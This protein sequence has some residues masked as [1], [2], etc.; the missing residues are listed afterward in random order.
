V[1]KAQ[2]VWLS[3]VAITLQSRWEKQFG[4]FPGPTHMVTAVQSA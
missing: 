4:Q 3:E 1:F 2:K